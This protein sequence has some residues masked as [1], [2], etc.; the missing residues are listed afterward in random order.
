MSSYSNQSGS[1]SKSTPVA[2]GSN[3]KYIVIYTSGSKKLIPNPDYNPKLC[4]KCGSY[5][6]FFHTCK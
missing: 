1:V 3:P 6:G 2:T 5:K 4:P